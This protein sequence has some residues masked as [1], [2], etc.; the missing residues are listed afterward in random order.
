MVHTPA[1]V[2]QSHFLDEKA[3]VEF[4]E[5]QGEKHGAFKDAAGTMLISTWYCDKVIAAAKVAG[6]RRL[7]REEILAK[8]NS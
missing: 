4:C 5:T 6:V 7:S 8:Y 2:A 1:F 3:F